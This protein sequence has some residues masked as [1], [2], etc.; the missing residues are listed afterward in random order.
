MDDT[1]IPKLVHYC[2]FGKSEKPSLV[3]KCISSW[4]EKLPDYKI[5]EW[6][7][8]NFDINFNTYV[9]NAYEFN[10][11][12]F[13]SDYVRI[14]ALYNYGG[15]YLDTDVEVFKSFDN[16]LSNESF[17]GFEQDNYVATS[18]IG[19]K[20]N[21]KILKEI[22]DIYDNKNFINNDG[23]I[24]NT[25]NVIIITNLIKEKGI[26]MNGEF[27]ETDCLT[28]YPQEYFSPYNYSN[29]KYLITDKSYCIHHFYKSWLPLNNR[30]KGYIKKIIATIIG[31]S[32]IE[33]LRKIIKG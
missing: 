13:V 17:W 12:A 11:F 23:T 28:F 2:W 8:S 14:Y 26:V 32:N 16:L 22:L 3:K 4:S 10:K 5:I 27:Q 6:N 21:N 33:K 29:C 9:K 19:S 31:S 18:T 15:I 7:E 24:D 20:K 1:K 25:T 30:V